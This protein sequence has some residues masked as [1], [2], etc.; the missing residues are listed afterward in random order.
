MACFIVVCFIIAWQMMRNAPKVP[1]DTDI[2]N[3]HFDRSET[4]HSHRA[5]N[6][7]QSEKFG[8]VTFMD[9]A[10]MLRLYY[11]LDAF[12][13]DM[14]AEQKDLTHVQAVKRDLWHMLEVEAAGK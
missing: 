10:Q 1:D 6:V 11:G 9:R 7:E 13:R 4:D 5:L 8:A 3:N 14:I 12:T 2:F